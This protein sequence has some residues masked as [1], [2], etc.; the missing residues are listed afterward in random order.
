MGAPPS[1]E[2][3]SDVQDLFSP[4]GTVFSLPDLSVEGQVGVEEWQRFLDAA[5]TRYEV[6]ATY[7]GR[8]VNEPLRALDLLTRSR[9][10]AAMLSIRTGH[11]RINGFCT[12]E[13]IR[14]DFQDS[15][16][17]DQNTFDEFLDFMRMLSAAT[18][19][20]VRGFLEGADW[21]MMELRDGTFRRLWP[22]K[23]HP[24]FS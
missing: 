18:S 6:T 5:R 20:S 1:S 11:L 19:Q 3:F 23:E 22:S 15:E 12:E 24:R 4:D 10:V 17:H 14:F 9:E 2:Q 7:D 8:P 21:P 16:I 13:A